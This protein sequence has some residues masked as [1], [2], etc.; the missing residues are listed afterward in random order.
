MKDL[1][2][3]KPIL[4]FS[5]DKINFGVLSNVV[6]R[7]VHAVELSELPGAPTIVD[8]VINLA[9]D[10]IPI[11]NFRK[12]LKKKKKPIRLSDKIII[13]KT[14]DLKFG[15]FIDF[16]VGLKDVNITKYKETDEVIP[17]TN[18]IVEGVAIIDK[19]LVLI[20]DVNKFF[21]IQE[22]NKLSDALEK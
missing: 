16:I 17:H 11:V 7:V 5:I 21:T 13:V 6:E 1:D 19:E 10:T 22:K 18:I 12:R 4:V 8:G 15:F 9:G 3:S 20:H 2:Q 14:D